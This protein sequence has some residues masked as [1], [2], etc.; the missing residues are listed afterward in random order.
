M[1]N[2]LKNQRFFAVILS[3][4]ISVFLVAVFVYAATTIGS[5]ISTGGTLTVTGESFLNGGARIAI[6]NAT[7][8]LID[9]LTVGTSL[10]GT[11]FN[12]AFDT[13]F[14]A[15]TTWSGNLTVDGTINATAIDA[16]DLT[17]TAT[18]DWTGLF[19]GQEGSY[20]LNAS[21]LTNFGIPFYTYFNATN[22]DALSEGAT[23]LYYT[24]TRVNTVLNATTT[25]DLT[26][27]E[28]TNFTFGK[29][30]SSDSVGY[31]YLPI[32]KF[33]PIA[34]PSPAVRGKCFMDNNDYQLNCYD[35]TTWHQ[36]W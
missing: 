6:L 30:T 11:G 33:M 23:N 24:D 31:I 15:T 9:T 4:L 20:Y 26:T 32:I 28:A 12:N 1:K 16:T 25:L 36:L 29:A 18:D 8:T 21:N 10:S 19:D 17:I 13:R 5:N 22:T 34:T 2:P 7:T 35:G 27:L 14:I 3:V